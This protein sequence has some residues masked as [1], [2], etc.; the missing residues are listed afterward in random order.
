MRE[1]DKYMMKRGKG[2]C[3]VEEEAKKL[4]FYF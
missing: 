2:N 4:S 1:K 3:R